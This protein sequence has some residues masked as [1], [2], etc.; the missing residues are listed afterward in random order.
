MPKDE[1]FPDDPMELVGLM[2][3]DPSGDGLNEMAKCIIEE[4]I[5]MGF[6]DDEIMRLFRNPY[7]V[8]TSMIRREK[9]EDFV[10]NLIAE[11]R[12]KWGYWKL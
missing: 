9:G 11:T 2:L 3:P 5:Q 8:A 6:D 1:F 12:K 4:F 7:F 10:T